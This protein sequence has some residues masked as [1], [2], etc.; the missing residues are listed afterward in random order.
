MAIA[1]HPLPLHTDFQA[2]VDGTNGNTI[3]HPVHARLGHSEFDVTGA[4]DHGA[5]ETRKTILLDAQTYAPKTGAGNASA[6]LEDFLRLAVKA[7]KPPM[8]GGIRFNTKVRI[9]PGDV[10]VIERLELDGSFGLAGVKFTSEEVQQKIAGLSHRAQG[11]PNDHDPN[12]AA[13]FQGSFHLHNEQLTLPDLRFTLPGAQVNLAGTYAL[14]SGAMNFQ[15]T[16]RLDAT[17]SQMTTGFK[18]KLL[19]PLDPLFR[20]DGAGTVLPIAIS[21]TSGSPSFKLD[22]GRVLRRN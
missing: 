13:D 21:G 3:L 1:G 22:I 9:P 20:R 15:G 14:H 16:A 10:P 8:T 17:V 4:I 11:D 6:R 12:V 5:V 2:T 18:S 7:A 19:K